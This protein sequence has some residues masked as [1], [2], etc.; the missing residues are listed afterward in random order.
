MSAG[1]VFA[2]CMSATGNA[3]VVSVVMSQ[4]PATVCIQVPM[5]ETRLAAQSSRKV[6]SLRGWRAG[7]GLVLVKVALLRLTANTPFTRRALAGEAAARHNGTHALI[8]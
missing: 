6:R 1:S 3:S 8:D 2:V 7:C 5:F 4:A